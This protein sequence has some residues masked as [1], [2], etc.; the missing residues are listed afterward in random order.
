LEGFSGRGRIII[1][2]GTYQE[3]EKLAPDLAKLCSALE[4]TGLKGFSSG[5]RGYEVPWRTIGTEV[6]AKYQ[7]F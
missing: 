2:E 3:L 7:G 1:G 4:V 5:L 6:T